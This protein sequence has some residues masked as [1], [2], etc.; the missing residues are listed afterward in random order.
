VWGRTAPLLSRGNLAVFQH[1][2]AQIFNAIR[3]G[4]MKKARQAM[5]RHLGNSQARHRKLAVNL[6]PK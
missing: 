2:H 4:S 5:Q 1:E 6:R 3:A